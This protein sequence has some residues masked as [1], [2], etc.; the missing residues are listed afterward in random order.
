M[1]DA[2]GH[3]A[4]G[5][6]P[7]SIVSSLWCEVIISNGTTQIREAKWS[8]KMSAPRLCT[9]L[10]RVPQQQ[11]GHNRST[12]GHVAYAYSLVYTERM[13]DS[14]W[15]LPD[16]APRQSGDVKSL[17]LPRKGRKHR[18]RP[19]GRMLRSF[20]ASAELVSALSGLDLT[21]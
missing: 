10:V 5:E 14:A 20:V 3:G 8:L 2:A 7:V 9:K 6:E 13:L 1:Q 11:Q 4:Q 19:T 17:C 16:Q 18:R 12:D 15:G 21:T